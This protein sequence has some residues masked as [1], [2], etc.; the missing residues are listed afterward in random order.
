[1]KKKRN[2]VVLNFDENSFWWA[3]NCT[4]PEEAMKRY[5]EDSEVDK[6]FVGQVV[7][8]GKWREY[9]V[10]VQPRVILGEMNRG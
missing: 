1:M 5:V 3:D 4:S 10:T 6:S 9:E 7:E 2:Y 8:A